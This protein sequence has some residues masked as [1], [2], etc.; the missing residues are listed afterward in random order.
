MPTSVRTATRIF[1]L[2][3]VM[4]FAVSLLS[5]EGATGEKDSGHSRRVCRYGSGDGV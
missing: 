5:A 4:R 2:N 1:L 3:A